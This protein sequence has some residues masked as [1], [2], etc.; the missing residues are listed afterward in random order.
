MAASFLLW[1][2]RR[3]FLTAWLAGF[4]VLAG[5]MA[6]TAR[7]GEA[8]TGRRPIL[9]PASDVERITHPCEPVKG[10]FQLAALAGVGLLAAHALRAVKGRERLGGRGVAALAAL[11]LFGAPA[12]AEGDKARPESKP[13]IRHFTTGG[14][15]VAVECFTPKEEGKHPVLIALHAVDGIEGDCAS[16]YR[17]AARRAAGRGYLVLLVHYFDCTGSEKKDVAGYRELFHGYFRRK[18][19]TAE[20]ARKMAALSAE[21]VGATCDAVAYARTLPNADG[22][23]VG[24]VGFSLGATLA[25]TA[26]T[27]HDLKLAALVDLFGTLPQDLWPDPLKK[28]PPTLVIHGEDDRVVPVEQAYILVGLLSLRNVKHEAKVYRD[29]GHMFSPDGKKTQWGPLL[30]AQRRTNEFLDKHLKP[31]AV[32]ANAK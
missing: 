11:A 19:H 30:A 5:L 27:K 18:E 16:R 24:L 28:L 3:G 14:K 25:L 4:A 6:P 8:V 23:R 9:P 21:W 2:A 31:G 20:E 32:A 7:A 1:A 13:D 15:E 10:L 22:D 29:A 12:F 26:A 17:A